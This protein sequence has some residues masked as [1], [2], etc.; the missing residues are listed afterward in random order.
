M[1]REKIREG[2]PHCDC[3][4]TGG[5]EKCQATTYSGITVI[6]ET[7]DDILRGAFIDG[8]LFFLENRDGDKDAKAFY[9][10]M[11]LQ[12]KKDLSALGVVI[13]VDREHPTVSGDGV[14]VQTRFEPL[15]EGKE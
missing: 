15:I 10:E 3:G 11:I 2:I 9:K 14:F 6:T 12:L 8:G 5:C 1:K 13:K 7:I 4:L